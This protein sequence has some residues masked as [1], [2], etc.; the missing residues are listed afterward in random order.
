[1][2]DK[3][4]LVVTYGTLQGH[5][6]MWESR[7]SCLLGRH[8]ECGITLPNDEAHKTISRHHALLDISPPNVRIRDFGSLNGTFVNGEK[9]GAR[10]RNQSPEEAAKHQFPERELQHGDEVRIG[11]TVFRV[12]VQQD[13]VKPQHLAPSG[14]VSDVIQG[15]LAR[16]DL[17]GAAA[18]GAD[19]SKIKGYEIIQELGRGGMGAVYLARHRTTN[20]TVALKVM[21]PNVAISDHA[22][23][24]FLREAELSKALNHPNVVE[25]LGGGY[26]GGTFFF[27]LEYCPG[28]SVYDYFHEPKDHPPT[29]RDAFVIALQVLDGL[30]YIA[31]V[32]LE[33]E[34]QDGSTMLANGLVH[35]DLSPDNI[36]LSEQNGTMVAKI[37][38]VGLGK[39]F[40]TAGLSGMT[41]TGG[42]PSGK[43][44]FMPRQQ[45]INFKFA[46]PEVDVWAAAATLYWMLSG[47]YPRDFPNGVD[48]YKIVLSTDPVPIRN[49][50]PQ[51]PQP[52]ADVID[53]ALRDKSDLHYK[54]ALDLHRDLLA[55]LKEIGIV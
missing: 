25:M 12:H 39:A 30:D 45:V 16:A 21:L 1:M 15:L 51:C 33:V 28:G 34:L 4:A 27:T 32:P 48:P 7:D 31:N 37:S 22:R 23:A 29:A 18:S 14:N 43:V 47:D 54:S 36:L 38:D 55:A 20:E 24:S 17:P 19:V 6:W 42:G 13:K 40:D 44:R 11:D 35:R 49:R 41:M 26:E 52:I 8:S 3:I 10:S 46:K 5:S 9:I 2:P 50:A 53:R